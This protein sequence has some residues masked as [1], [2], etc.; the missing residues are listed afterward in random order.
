MCLEM[1]RTKKREKKNLKFEN[2]NHSESILRAT[3][4]KLDE[5]PLFNCENEKALIPYAIEIFVQCEIGGINFRK[6]I[7]HIISK[8]EL[9]LPILNLYNFAFY[10]LHILYGNILFCHY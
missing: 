10:S 7:Y 8:F 1:K 5:I 4:F 6:Q 9:S 2:K 3:I